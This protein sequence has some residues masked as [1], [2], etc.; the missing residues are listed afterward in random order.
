MYLQ[1]IFYPFLT[2]FLVSLLITPLVIKFA[3][4]LG[5]VD[6][7]KKRFHPA[8]THKGTIPRAGGLA[9]FFGF[10]TAS[11]TFLPL[12]KH[13]GGILL[14]AIIVIIVGFVV[15]VINCMLRSNIL[16]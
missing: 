14:G 11:L 7:P 5:L 1:L 15:C 8:H 9:I 2:S 16:L 13:L 3:N 10:L 12:D 6:N 4:F